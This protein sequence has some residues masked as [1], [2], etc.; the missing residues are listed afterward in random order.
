MVLEMVRA[1]HR[2]G[3]PAKT[4]YQIYFLDP[5][6]GGW[7]TL[8]GGRGSELACFHDRS[9]AERVVAELQEAYPDKKGEIRE[10][11]ETYWSGRRFYRHD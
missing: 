4:R 10:V 11:P 7:P 1:D 5:E 9:E 3:R 2:I 8:Q 6:L